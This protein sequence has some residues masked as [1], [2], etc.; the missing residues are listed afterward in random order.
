M[1]ETGHT[2]DTELLPYIFQS[3]DLIDR[4]TEF[5][6]DPSWSG[7]PTCR[8][9]ASSCPSPSSRW[10]GWCSPPHPAGAAPEDIADD[11]AWIVGAVVEG[12]ASRSA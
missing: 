3:Q 7:S 2:G 4:A 8:C 11:L 6:H 1:L 5:L 12:A 10:S 9:R